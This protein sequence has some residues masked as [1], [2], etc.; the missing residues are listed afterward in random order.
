VAIKVETTATACVPDAKCGCGGCNP[1]STVPR[2]APHSYRAA[3]IGNARTELGGHSS[4]WPWKCKPRVCRASATRPAVVVRANQ[5]RGS[6]QQF[7]IPTG[8][9]T[10]AACARNLEAIE[11]CGHESRNH[12]YGV[13]PRCKMREWWVQSNVESPPTIPHPYRAAC[14]GG[15]CAE[16]CGHR[17]MWP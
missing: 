2:R 3:Y 12:C 16:L 5:C 8:P 11:V 15:P 4:R 13:R 9:R 10:L 14:T 7:R 6:P 1:M 17:S